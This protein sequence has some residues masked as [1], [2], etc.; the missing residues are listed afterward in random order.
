MGNDQDAPPEEG[1]RPRLEIEYC[2]RCGFLLRS[3]WMAQ[4]ILQAFPEE[5]A[6]LAL[7]PGSG[8][9]FIIRLDGEKLFSRRAEGRFPQ[10]KEIK[11]AIAE[12]LDPERRFGHRQGP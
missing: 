3:A 12:R 10:P 7:V 1:R 2:R 8:G 11:Q 5:V 6:E 9:H 4:E